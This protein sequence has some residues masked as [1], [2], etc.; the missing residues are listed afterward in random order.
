MELG[1]S[2]R[3]RMHQ[4]VVVVVPLSPYKSTPCWRC[5][6]V[7]TSLSVS[8]PSCQALLDLPANGLNYFSVFGYSPG[9][10]I[11]EED[12]RKRYF[13]LSKKTHPDRFINV[14]APEKEHATRWSAYINKS[15]QT[16]RDPKSRAEYLLDLYQVPPQKA[17]KVPTDLAESYFELQELLMEEAGRAKAKQFREHLGSLVD[18]NEKDFDMLAEVWE[19][20]NAKDQFLLHLQE[21]LNKQKYLFSMLADLERKLGNQSGNRWH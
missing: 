14:P 21:H 4:K 10:K 1:L 15:H 7:V 18:Q 17:A 12:L 9:L 19:K 16:L 20:T 3:T 5:K 11:D 2:L 6:A 8:C 13:D